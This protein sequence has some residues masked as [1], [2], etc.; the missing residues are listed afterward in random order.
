MEFLIVALPVGSRLP[1][2]AAELIGGA[3]GM[4]PQ[5]AGTVSVAV[6]GKDV[7]VACR[8]AAAYGADRVYAI[9]DEMLTDFHSDA[10]LLALQ[11]LVKETEPDMVLFSADPF[12]TEIAPR[13]AR[14]M[15]TGA[16]LGCVDLVL[17]GEGQA[18]LTR[19]VYGGKAMAQMV[20]TGRPAVATVVPR[21]F[22]APAREDANSAEVIDRAAGIDPKSLPTRV[23]EVR[24]E[25]ST[26]VRLE[27]AKVVVSGG[28]GL[29]DSSGFGCLEELARV[30]GGAVGS[31]RAPVDAG[32]VPPAMQVGQTGKNVAPEL[33]IAVG[34][35]GAAQHLAGMGR[36]KHVVVINKDPE[37]PFF[38]IA[39]LGVVGDY[40]KLVPLLTEKLRAQLRG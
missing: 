13:L 1:S 11:G 17:D 35:S 23:E 37:A 14:R 34:I 5:S 40:K 8:D 29:G 19:P 3:R 32:W 38:G 24:Q 15:G 36:S 25:E 30:V 12:T 6:L 28:R 27:D 26:G 33:Y 10:Y 21:S 16:V 20:V 4:A 22:E 9:N 18:I 2:P 31:S 39:E 7:A